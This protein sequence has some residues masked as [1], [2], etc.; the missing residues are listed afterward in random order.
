MRLAAWLA[1]RIG[2]CEGCR[3]HGK[4]HQAQ[5]GSAIKAMQGLDLSPQEKSGGSENK[6]E[7]FLTAAVTACSQPPLDASD[8]GFTHIRGASAAA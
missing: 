3:K 1:F 6:G 7:P 4:R 5:A 8:G 2:C